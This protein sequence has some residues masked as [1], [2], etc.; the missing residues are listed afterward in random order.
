LLQYSSSAAY[1][2][3]QLKKVRVEATADPLALAA[4]AAPAP[5]PSA[6][7]DRLRSIIDEKRGRAH[8]SKR[9]AD[10]QPRVNRKETFGNTWDPRVK[11]VMFAHRS[12]ATAAG[13]QMLANLFG[14]DAPTPTAAANDTTATE[15]LAS[16]ARG[17]DSDRP[18]PAAAVGASGSVDNRAAASWWQHPSLPYP[19]PVPVDP[20]V[21]V[22]DVEPWDEDLLCFPSYDAGL[23][24]AK[25]DALVHHIPHSVGWNPEPDV[26]PATLT[27]TVAE[28]KK[29]AHIRRVE[30]ASEQQ[31][32]QHLGLAPKQEQRLTLKHLNSTK[33]LSSVSGGPT[34]LESLIREQMTKRVVDH[35]E[36]NEKRHTAAAQHQREHF[37]ETLER[38]AGENPRIAVYRIDNVTDERLLTTIKITAKEK[39]L[40]GVILWLAGRAALIVLVGGE[41]PLRRV[42]AVMKKKPAEWRMECSIDRL[43]LSVITELANESLFFQTAVAE[44]AKGERVRLIRPKTN[45][46]ALEALKN[47]QLAHVW[48]AAVRIPV[49]GNLYAGA[50]LGES[51]EQQGAS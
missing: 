25:I 48:A 8:A 30:K 9:P 5:Q 16:L 31:Q 27:R 21:A 38:R 26:P 17:D 23:D 35:Y 47:Q 49:S 11:Q 32:N 29:E 24:D 37:F 13:N 7:A 44:G 36:A 43:W 42:E 3:P 10:T 51:A 39:L 12:H 28:R 18:S 40:R 1:P 20:S 4:A 22:P 6:G 33:L 14:V 2:M 45:R 41:Q 34:E 15:L 50:L 46:D 19:T